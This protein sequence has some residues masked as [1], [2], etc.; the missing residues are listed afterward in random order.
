MRV[1]FKVNKL[2]NVSEGKA[3]VI[4][5]RIVGT[6]R[7]L[8]V[9][10]RISSDVSVKFWVLTDVSLALPKP[11]VGMVIDLACWDYHGKEIKL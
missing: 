1:E 3:I 4:A 11:V 5:E 2:V 8:H 6:L 9:E 10:K 7:L